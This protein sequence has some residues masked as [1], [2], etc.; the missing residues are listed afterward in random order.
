[1][2]LQYGVDLI[3][4]Y[5]P[6]FWGADG[7]EAFEQHAA[8]DPRRFWDRI[9]ESVVA[10]G[11][12][13]V[14]VTFPPGDWETAVRTYESAAG[15]A[16]YLREAGISV[17]SGFFSG[18]EEH[19]NLE[20]PGVQRQ[21]IDE[22]LR[23]SEFLQQAG[24]SVLVSGMPMRSQGTPEQPN[25][26]D[27][28]Y[29]KRVSDLINRVGAASLSQGVRLALHTEVGSVFC[30]RRDIDLFLSLT[31]PAYVDLCPDTAHIFLGGVSPVEVLA[32]HYER[33]T[34]AHW[35]DA[36]GR[37]PNT[38]LANEDRFILEAEYFRRVGTGDVDWPGWVRGLD[39][40]GFE[41]WAILELDAAPNPVQDMTAARKF[42]Q[43]LVATTG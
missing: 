18:L 7:R 14:E 12:T 15:F 39:K 16:S 36:V 28:D 10:A 9:V 22:A 23:Y 33:V 25:F 40:A 37:W 30:V 32:D 5:H 21:V 42:A 17:I 6:E 27:F 29:A 2:Q 34:I 43:D 19:E 35:K 8:S 26:V 24:A 31:D 1:M 38:D 4:F 41:G 11:I 13:G 3:T 20:D